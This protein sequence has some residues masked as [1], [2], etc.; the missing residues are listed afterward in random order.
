MWKRS[1]PLEI[2]LTMIQ[3]TV[4]KTFCSKTNL[5]VHLQQIL[6]SDKNELAGEQLFFQKNVQNKELHMM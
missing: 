1:Q 5:N 4:L 3:P 6:K 2:K